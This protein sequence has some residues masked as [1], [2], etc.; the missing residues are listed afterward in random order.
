[1]PDAQTQNTIQVEVVYG[2]AE[3]QVLLSVDVPDKS[4]IKDVIIASNIIEHFPEIDLEKVK[5]GLFGKLT[6]MDQTV[7]ARDRIEIYRPLIADPKEVR[8]RRAA[9]GKKLKKGGAETEETPSKDK[10]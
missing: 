10:K 6:K 5:V 1:M 3:E 9:E 2:L 8:K 7:R 4:L